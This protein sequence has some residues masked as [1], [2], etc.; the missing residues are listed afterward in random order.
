MLRISRRVMSRRSLNNYQ[1]KHKIL[2]RIER[3]LHRQMTA[4]SGNSQA[5]IDELSQQEQVPS[6]RLYLI[7]NGIPLNS[8]QANDRA[9]GRAA[10]GLASDCLVLIIVAN[11]VSYK[12]HADLLDALAE[13]RAALPENWTLLVVGGDSGAGT[14]LKAKT[15]KLGLRDYVRFV[16]LKRNVPELLSLS[17][18]A[19]LVS[20]E[21]GFS[22]AVLE[23]MAAG[24]PVIA[25]SV[26][27][28]P[29]AVVEG[30]TGL[31]VP[32]K[33]PSA[34]AQAILRLANDPAACQQMEAKGHARVEKHFSLEACVS[35]YEALYSSI[36]NRSDA[37]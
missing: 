19:I 36:L 2:A 5:V 35:G 1:A 34:L 32:P 9:Q 3:R 33:N 31:L 29:E 22:N 13:I 8:C 18:I 37:P 21:E 30:S 17:D 23:A 14:R 24:L 10:M 26:G 15:T 25:T 12:G 28:N 4:V 6:E 20:H 11:L 7:Y 16:G 27:G